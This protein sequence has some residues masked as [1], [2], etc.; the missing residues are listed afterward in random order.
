M[1]PHTDGWNSTFFKPCGVLR[2]TFLYVHLF[3][4]KMNNI[5]FAILAIILIAGCSS[6][7]KL[8]PVAYN[9]TETYT[10]QE[11]YTEEDCGDRQYKY[12]IEDV[13]ST[14]IGEKVELKYDVVNLD[15]ETFEFRG[16]AYWMLGEAAVFD[17]FSPE[18]CCVYKAE[19]GSSVEITRVY[20]EA[21]N[22]LW[23][24]EYVSIPNKTSCEQVTKYKSVEK[25]RIVT[26][27]RNESVC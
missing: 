18:V 12:K 16:G 7:C 11:P 22:G 17:T 10:A 27:Y 19:K 26:K 5:L 8:S 9:E 20:D 21:P 6:Q 25:T 4:K 15:T 13:K 23:G 2:K 14:R 24:K 1:C 3:R